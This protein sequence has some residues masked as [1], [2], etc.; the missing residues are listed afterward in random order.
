MRTGEKF[1][2]IP[3]INKCEIEDAATCKSI[4]F[5]TKMCNGWYVRK[6]VSTEAA[7]IAAIC[8]PRGGDFVVGEGC[9]TL[10]ARIDKAN[11]VGGDLSPSI[12]IWRRIRSFVR[13]AD[14]TRL[15]RKTDF[16]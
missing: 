16:T 1:Q 12:N 11:V 6:R 14:S 8:F 10:S 15:F 5:H 7:N 9:L 2:Q 4:R 3:R 13:L